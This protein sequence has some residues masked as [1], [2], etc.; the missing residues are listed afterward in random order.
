MEVSE[1]KEGA[2]E[3]E[4]VADIASVGYYI[5]Q[6]RVINSSAVRVL[7]HRPRRWKRSR[8]CAGKAIRVLSKRSRTIILAGD[9]RFASGLLL[10]KKGISV[11]AYRPKR[12]L[13][14]RSIPQY[15]FTVTLDVLHVRAYTTRCEQEIGTDRP[16]PSWPSL[17]WGS[18]SVQSY[19]ACNAL[20]GHALFSL[21]PGAQIK[22]H[23]DRSLGESIAEPPKGRPSR[24]SIRDSAIYIYARL[25]QDG[26][27]SKKT[28]A[29]VHALKTNSHSLR[30]RLLRR[31]RRSLQKHP[32]VLAKRY[33][34]FNRIPPALLPTPAVALKFLVATFLFPRFC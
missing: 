26:S 8:S 15:S 5:L 24:R 19:L 33:H 4:L 20:H 9:I 27:E 13:C 14:Q 7:L 32:F 30:W 11:S 6:G 29:S 31:R 23:R 3:R 2:A 16:L 10:R 18:M 21:L 34:F 12:E 1:N 28:T 17:R 22:C 25:D